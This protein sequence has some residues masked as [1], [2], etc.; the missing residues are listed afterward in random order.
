MLSVTSR[1]VAGQVTFGIATG[2]P[3]PLW[4]CVN[5]LSSG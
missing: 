5:S 3:L 1:F 2:A 4:C